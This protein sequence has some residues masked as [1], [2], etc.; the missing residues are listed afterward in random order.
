MCSLIDFQVKYCEM[1]MNAWNPSEHEDVDEEYDVFFFVCVYY[2]LVYSRAETPFLDWLIFSHH[3]SLSQN[4]CNTSLPCLPSKDFIHLWFGWYWYLFLFFSSFH[5]FCCCCFFRSMCCLAFTIDHVIDK[6]HV[7]KVECLQVHK[8]PN[9]DR[10]RVFNARVLH[11]HIH[12][13]RIVKANE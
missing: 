1:H 10:T 2:Y 8:I 12:N 6:K 3:C 11:T 4:T 5:R 7:R 9:A 13:D